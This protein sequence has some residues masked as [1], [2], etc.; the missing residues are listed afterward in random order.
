MY[1][2]MPMTHGVQN[3]RRISNWII[4]WRN[5]YCCCCKRKL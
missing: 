2:V 4:S 5:F 3:Q 1:D